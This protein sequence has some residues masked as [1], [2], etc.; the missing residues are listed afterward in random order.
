MPATITRPEGVAV[1]PVNSTR[2][3]WYLVGLSGMAAY[4]AAI[5]WQA[6]LVS[7]PL[8]RS[9]GAAEFAAYHQAYNEAIPFVVIL[10]GFLTFAGAIAFGWARPTWVGRRATR[11]VAVSGA[12]A[13]LSTVLWAIPRHNELDRTGPL[14]ATI[15]SL[16][17]ANAVRTAALSTAAVTLAWCV[18]RR[19]LG[20]KGT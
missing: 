19:L 3:T 20:P 15:D 2:R 17:Q 12:V 5:S 10:P 18:A 16:L 8:Y 11:V 6:Q 7:Y 14:P 4:S 1:S 13:L 9:V